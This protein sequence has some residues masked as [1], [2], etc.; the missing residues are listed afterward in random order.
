MQVSRL[1]PH[2]QLLTFP[3]QIVAY[4]YQVHG[5]GAGGE[6]VDAPLTDHHDLRVLVA[7]NGG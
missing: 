6:R 7:L 1:G 3:F 5:H 2:A 4:P